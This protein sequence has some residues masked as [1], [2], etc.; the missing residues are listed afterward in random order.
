MRGDDPALG[1]N[2]KPGTMAG[3]STS[4]W[5]GRVIC[6]PHPSAGRAG[7]DHGEFLWVIAQ[8]VTSPSQDSKEY[9]QT[10]ASIENALL[11]VLWQVQQISEF[12]IE[13]QDYGEL[14]LRLDGTPVWY[15]QRRQALRNQ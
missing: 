3:P 2:Q 13:G 15:F 1:R 11:K 7:S 4:A 5:F 6:R 12:N 10:R 14:E 9:F 8:H